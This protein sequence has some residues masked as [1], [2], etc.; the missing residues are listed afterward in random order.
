MA[1]PQPQ[2]R[3]LSPR[4]QLR[5]AVSGLADLL[6]QPASTRALLYDRASQVH[7]LHRELG[8]PDAL[9]AA[10]LRNLLKDLRGKMP[11]C[12]YF[13]RHLTRAADR[14]ANAHRSR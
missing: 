13:A 3:P 14:L 5:A 12:G 4:E 10:H 6:L 7:R 1:L 9:L 8:E 2:P 11:D